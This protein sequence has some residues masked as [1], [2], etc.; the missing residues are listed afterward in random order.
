VYE[1]TPNTID[2][3]EFIFSLV[4]DDR[5]DF[6]SLKKPVGMKTTVMVEPNSQR[7]FENTLGNRNIEY[8]VLIEDLQK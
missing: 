1:I 6:W 5:F 4:D 8:V 3:A 7:W 2:D